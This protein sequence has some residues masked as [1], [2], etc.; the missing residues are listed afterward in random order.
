VSGD[1]RVATDLT[2]LAVSGNHSVRPFPAAD[3][4]RLEVPKSLQVE[5]FV[6]IGQFAPSARR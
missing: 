6:F 2:S 3:Q 1:D 4:C 5:L